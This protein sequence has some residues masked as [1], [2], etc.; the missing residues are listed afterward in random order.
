MAVDAGL[1][2]LVAGTAV[3]VSLWR[4]RRRWRA[5]VGPPPPGFVPTAEHCIDPTTGVVE[6]VWYNPQTGERRY[7]PLPPPD[8]PPPGQGT[9][10]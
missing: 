4:E 7:R 8:G 2:V 3:A 6:V 1:G 10:T 9:G 5:P